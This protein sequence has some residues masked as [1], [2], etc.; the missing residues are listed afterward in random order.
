MNTFEELETDTDSLS[1]ALAHDNLYNCTRPSKKAEWEAL[2]EH[3]CDDFFN[4]DAVQKFFPRT[5]CDNHKKNNKRE[6]G[7][8]M[9]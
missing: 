8:F 4:V 6:P 1:L 9:E 5:W 2:R 3:D 7:L